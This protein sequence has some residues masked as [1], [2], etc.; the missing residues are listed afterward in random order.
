MCDCIETTDRWF[1][2]HDNPTVIDA[3][4]SLRDE[5]GIRAKVATCIPWWVEKKRGRRATSLV[6]TYCPLCGEK[7]PDLTEVADGTAVRPAD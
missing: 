5:G 6:A 7:Y 2:E 4:I 1:K 3:A